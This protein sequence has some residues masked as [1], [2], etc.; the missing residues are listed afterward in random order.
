MIVGSDSSVNVSWDR[1]DI[2]G[3]TGYIVYYSQTGTSAK[4]QSIN[5][6]KSTT[7]S[8]VIDGLMNNVEYQFQVAVIAELDGNFIVGERSTLNNMSKIVV[9]LSTVPNPQGIEQYR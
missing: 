2:A 7:N 1:L 3:I 4:E 9:A 8:V 6:T 5:V